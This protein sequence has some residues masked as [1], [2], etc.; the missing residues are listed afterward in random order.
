MVGFAIVD[1]H[2]HLYDPENLSYP[3]IT[4]VESLRR[5]FLPADYQAA[6]GDVE[7][8]EIVFLEV[9]VADH[10]CIDE[11]L[12]V[13]EQAKVEPRIGAI[14]ANLP[15]ER[16]GAIEADLERLGEIPLVHGVRRLIQSQA[17]PEFCLQPSFIE[18]VNL[19]PKYGFSFDICIVHRQFANTLQFVKQCPNV[20]FV[21]DHI[22]K[23]GVKAGEL[24]PWRD[25]MRELASYP[26]VRCKIS[27]VATE[28]DHG[29][30]T[31]AQLR[32]YIDHAIET[33]GFDRVMFGGDWPV[34]TL[35]VDYP[36]WLGI[37]EEAVAGCSEDE[38]KK[39]FRDNARAFYRL[40]QD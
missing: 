34:S 18:G 5:A 1:S 37:V 10:Q 30:W 11:A 36:Q 26:N 17:N 4:Q 14:V 24:D 6:C 33:F 2:V 12:W 13:Q 9:A 23:P 31:K 32:P 3:A 39:L 29:A 21:L 40:K 28:A 20:A 25:H 22:G 16:G 15:L 27:G 35:A 8:G 7:V 19:L 38:V